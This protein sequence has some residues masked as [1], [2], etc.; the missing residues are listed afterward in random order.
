MINENKSNSKKKR[1]DSAAS[2][3]ILTANHQKEGTLA[4]GLNDLIDLNYQPD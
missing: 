4:D 3:V 1:R 2:E